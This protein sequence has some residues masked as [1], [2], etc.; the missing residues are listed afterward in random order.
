V[1]SLPRSSGWAERA[2]RRRRDGREGEEAETTTARGD[3]PWLRVVVLD[4]VYRHARTMFRHLAKL[5]AGRP[6]PHVALHPTTL[7][8]YS[9]AQHGYA[10]AS[11]LSTARSDDP[12]AMRVCTVEAF[13]LLLEELGESREACTRPMVGA[14]IVNNGA[15]H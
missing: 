8:V 10:A 12:A 3:L 14:V 1:D 2:R 4:G 6:P 9:R 13:A 15:L 11:A 7:S 5:R